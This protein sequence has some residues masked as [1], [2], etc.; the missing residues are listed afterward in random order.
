[1][2]RKIV[3]LPISMA[4]LA[5]FACNLEIQA[6]STLSP[7]Q[8]ATL[9]AQT[10]LAMQWQTLAAAG[11]VTPGG[12]P[13]DT[14][15][16]PGGSIATV[17]QTALPTV[18]GTFTFTPSSTFTPTAT[19]T[20]LPCNWAQFVSDI[21]VADNWETTPSDHFTKTWR[22]KNIGSCTWT[23]GYSLVFDHGD[24]MSAPAAQQLTSGTVPPGA[25]IDVSVNLLSPA[26]PGTYQGYF[27]LRASDATIF[28]IG[29]SHD[30]AFWVKIKVV[31]PAPV[32]SVSQA[33][34]SVSVNPENTGHAVATCPAGSVVVGGGFDGATRLVAHNIGQTG[35][36]WEAYATNHSASAQTLTAYAICMTGAP[37]TTARI[38]HDESPA[39]G[40]TGTSS[41]TCSG[42]SVVTGLGFAADASKIWV[43]AS[44]TIGNTHRITGK[45][46]SGVA[47][48]LRVHTT[49]LTGTGATSVQATNSGTV[50]ADSIATMTIMCPAGT[51][52]TGGGFSL[53]EQANLI[54]LYKHPSANAMVIKVLNLTVTARAITGYAMCL[55]MA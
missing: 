11:T 2:K 48:I 35:N 52:V 6:A 41:A 32:L 28:G 31:T 47:S 38:W 23:S 43:S 7:Q 39:G 16:G 49:C 45:N 22:L 3:L 17:S 53:G 18:T 55:A 27:K 15:I 29:A 12:L 30:G 37:A 9:S 34:N 36:G 44:E 20:P 25:T 1:M 24:Q 21:T 54:G 19:Q 4:A 5:V 42:G 50:P 14:P 26:A 33:E 40:T 46:F 8:I 13:G 51:V 10:M